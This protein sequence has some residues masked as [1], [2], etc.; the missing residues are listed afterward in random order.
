M[1]GFQLI[2]SMFQDMWPSGEMIKLPRYGREEIRPAE[3][4]VLTSMMPLE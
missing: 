4:H 2:K 1:V 3:P